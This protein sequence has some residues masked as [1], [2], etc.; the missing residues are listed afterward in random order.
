VLL[1]PEPKTLMKNILDFT[2]RYQA[3]THCSKSVSVIHIP[4][5]ICPTSTQQAHESNCDEVLSL[6]SNAAQLVRP[7]SSSL[8]SV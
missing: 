1:E 3:Y 4:T 8:L 2:Y 7:R 6:F 5:A